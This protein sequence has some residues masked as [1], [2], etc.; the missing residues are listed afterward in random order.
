MNESL[1]III[2]IICA[3]LELVPMCKVFAKAGK[4]WRWALIPVYNLILIFNIAWMSGNWVWVILLTF[5]SVFFWNVFMIIALVLFAVAVFL[6]SFKISKKFW[7]PSLFGIVY[8]VCQ[9]VFRWILA[10]WNFEYHENDFNNYNPRKEKEKLLNA[11]KAADQKKEDSK[12][13]D[14]DNADN[15]DDDKDD[16]K[17]G[18]QSLIDHI[19]KWDSVVKSVLPVLWIMTLSVAAMLFMLFTAI[20]NFRD[21][22][23]SATELYKLDNFDMDELMNNEN[24]KD[25]VWG[26]NTINELLDINAEISD[27]VDSYTSFF[28]EMQSPY[29]N[30][31]SHILLPELNLWKDPFLGD[32]D[33]SIIGAKFLKNNP[34][35]D[36]TLI[37]TWTNFFK[38]L[39]S[40]NVI[41]NIEVWDMVEDTENNLYYIPISIQFTA[42]SKRSFLLLVEWLS[43]TSNQKNLSLINEFIYNLWDTIKD[44][45]WEVIESLKES[46]DT[47]L[48]DDTVIWYNLYN[49]IFGTGET[50]LV[51]ETV[52][53]DTI[54]STVSCNTSTSKED[55]LYKFREKFR[56]IPSL[57]YTLWIEQDDKVIVLKNFLKELPPIIKI[58]TFTFNRDN[59]LGYD[60]T[61]YGS[62]AYEWSLNINIYG[63]WITEAEV[64][65]ISKTLWNM[66]IWQDL[67]PSAAVQNIESKLTNIWNTV[68]FDSYSTS[69]LLELDGI[70]KEI[71]SNYDTLSNYNK[72]IKLFEIYR[73]M[74][75]WNVC[76]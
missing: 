23:K 6:P 70:I 21:L 15:K 26:A 54:K 18:V 38:N 32:I 14:K 17:W 62:I 45:K 65:E 42:N 49:W 12:W 8:F 68:K 27:S 1:W 64:L 60:I 56:G 71:E 10:F 3:V 48:Q 16:N 44:E 24:A 67:T 46:M 52:I 35:N 39:G 61:N 69:N 55:C 4:P 34:Y 25:D 57:A 36:V 22:N 30:L 74:K 59:S 40:D 51:T 72:V 33:T 20:N 37:T 7:M 31:M 75:E 11:A 29:K 13:D 9:P 50:K 43:I 5:V 73:M 47:G 19:K 2:W 66:C 63:K 41:K 53:Y 58:E 28:D 76:N